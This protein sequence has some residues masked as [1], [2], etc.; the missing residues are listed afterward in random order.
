MRQGLK[1][2]PQIISLKRS[3][4]VTIEVVSCYFHISNFN[5]EI[6]GRTRLHVEEYGEIGWE[7]DRREGSRQFIYADLRFARRR[8]RFPVSKLL[9]HI[10]DNWPVC[11][12]PATLARPHQG[13]PPPC[14]TASSSGYNIAVRRPRRYG[15][16][17]FIVLHYF[18][19]SSF[20]TRNP[21]RGR[22]RGREYEKIHRENLRERVK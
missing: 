1:N 20:V 6:H 22:E 5:P 2:F 15:K 18:R 12:P 7:E 10:L 19:F 21:E 16:N 17:P 3:Y 8:L 13:N 9:S 14:G 11:T 4:L